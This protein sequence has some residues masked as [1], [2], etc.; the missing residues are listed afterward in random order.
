MTGY[1][2]VLHDRAARQLEQYSDH[3]GPFEIERVEVEQTSSSIGDLETWVTIV[4][5][6]D[7]SDCPDRNKVYYTESD[8]VVRDRCVMRSWCMPDTQRSIA[9]VNELLAIADEG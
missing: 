8:P 9:M 3:V 6:H 2:R 1:R 7:G 5:W 4:F